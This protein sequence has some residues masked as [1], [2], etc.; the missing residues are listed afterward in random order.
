[1]MRLFDA[2]KRYIVKHPREQAYKPMSDEYDREKLYGILRELDLKELECTEEEKGKVLDFLRIS[3]ISHD[4]YQLF[5]KTVG[6]LL[7][8]LHMKGEDIVE[9][10]I[11]FLNL[12]H[13]TVSMKI[14]ETQKSMQDGIYMVQELTNQKMELPDGSKVEVKAAMEGATDATSMLCNYMRHHLEETYGSAETDS[15]RFAGTVKQLFQ[16]ADMMATFKQSYDNVLYRKSF[17]KVDMKACTIAFDDE[18]YRNEKLEAL[19]QVIMGDRVLHVRGLNREKGKKSALERYL[20]CYRVKRM[21]VKDGNV[22]LEFGQGTPRRHQEFL[23]EMQAAIDAYYEFLDIEMKLEGLNGISLA[24]VL[25]VW[26]ALQCICFE[27]TEQCKLKPRMIYTKEEM[28]DLPRKIK[29]AD[30]EDYLVKLTGLKTGNVR[31]VLKALE[32]DW[33]KYNYIWTSPLYRIKDYYC[34]PFIPIINSMP[35]NIIERMMQR[36]G[37]DL[38]QRGRDFERY[39]YEQIAGADRE[40]EMTCIASKQY[41]TKKKGEEIDL[42]IGLRDIV[43]LVEAK[44]IHYSMEPQNYRD[45]WNRLEH[46]AE[47]AQRKKAYMEAH[48][49]MFTEVGDVTKKKI[50]PVVLTNYPTYAGFEHEGVY[51][52]DAHTFLS[53]FVTGYMTMRMMTPVEDPIVD[54]KFFYKDEA[55]MSANFEGYLKDQPVK[56]TY[57]GRMVIEE[58]PLLPQMEP[59]KCTCKTAVYQ[60]DPGLDLTNGIGVR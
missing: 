25:G 57:M 18:D 51:V 35:Y 19:G 43:V 11:G 54:A 26:V 10:F 20:K 5:Y 52:I 37:Y 59:W 46:G 53:Y 27:I 23:R 8:D 30:L 55:E 40:Y 56:K 38:E 14:K 47:Q 31:L 17:V 36:G 28:G 49:E 21:K 1:M 9:Y 50:V 24:E 4:L 12:Q 58:I 29:V 41:G 16:I 44:C 45:A 13:I 42:L 7:G 48:P 22:T 34:V 39:V 6:E 15:N 33:T 32:V 3:D 2:F 60:G